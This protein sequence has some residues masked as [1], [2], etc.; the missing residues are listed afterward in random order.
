MN[1]DGGGCTILISPTMGLD[2]TFL[3]L[4][5]V[6]CIHWATRAT[7]KRKQVCFRTRERSVLQQNRLSKKE[8]SVRACVCVCLCVCARAC[9]RAC[10]CVC[11]SSSSACPTPITSL[12]YQPSHVYS[13]GIIGEARVNPTPAQPYRRPGVYSS[14]AAPRRIP[15][16]P[17]T[18]GAARHR[19]RL[20]VPPALSIKVSFS[21]GVA[22]VV[23]V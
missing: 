12:S 9:V 15:V 3:P 23:Y 18:T 10:V 20:P 5:G 21:R 13:R 7:W 2:S 1:A 22:S 11:V 17:P 4:G 6:H 16:W 8:W 19:H 14:T